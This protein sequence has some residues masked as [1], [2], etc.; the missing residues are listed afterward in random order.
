M[1]LRR[2]LVLNPTVAEKNLRCLFRF[3]NQ[4]AKGLFEHLR[5]Q[6]ENAVEP[7]YVLQTNREGQP[8]L[9][10][11]DSTPLRDLTDQK[12]RSNLK[13]TLQAANTIGEGT[14]LIW[15]CGLGHWLSGLSHV[16]RPA[17][18]VIVEPEYDI[19]FASMQAVDWTGILSSWPVLFLTDK[20]AEDKA[21]ELIETHGSLFEN[22]YHLLAGRRLL[23]HELNRYNLLESKI[24]TSR[25]SFFQFQQSKTDIDANKVAITSGDAHREIL[26]VLTDEALALGHRA[27]GIYR[28]GPI[29][30]FVDTKK[31]WQEALGTPLPAN[32]LSFTQKVF[33]SE[34]WQLMK[35]AGIKRMVWCY[36]DPFRYKF[37]DAFFENC[38]VIYCF[39]P[40]LTERL[41]QISPTPI[42][43]MPAATT[44]SH[45]IKPNDQNL[46]HIPI[47]FVGSTGLQRLDEQFIKLVAENAAPVKRLEELVISQ[48]SKGH[49]VPYDEL[50]E[51]DMAFKGISENERVCLLEDLCT[52]YL[53][54]HT[55]SALIGMPFSIYGD[56]GWANEMLVGQIRKAYAGK[57]PDFRRETPLIYNRSKINLNVF[58]VQCVNSPTVRMFDVMACGGFLL[59][60]YRP[61]LEEMFEPGVELETFHTP[62][63]LREK[64]TYYLDHD[65]ERERIAQR[66]CE[67]V[68]TKHRY[69]DRLAEIFNNEAPM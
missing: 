62:A 23:D 45:G 30:R 41:Q 49:H 9:L 26:D 63:E 59:T 55:L 60:E 22:G 1:F 33:T 37:G 47:S 35:E 44:F 31:A 2:K 48:L 3:Q 42:Q 24:K 39:D 6:R 4:T 17:K 13:N 14:L 38:D 68:L 65:D 21:F 5:I 57:A 29:S 51:I 58:N 69:R 15:S 28:S 40:F 36:D 34:Q 66:G 64:V 27:E 25:S 20:D 43:Y 7:R 12:F 19:L 53:R 46:P 18:L 54:I 52:F 16:K 50:M 10:K 8:T 32:V 11:V 67:K 56:E 61:F